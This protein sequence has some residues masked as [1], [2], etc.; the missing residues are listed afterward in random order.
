MEYLDTKS[1]SRYSETYNYLKL[2][3]LSDFEVSGT[4]GNYT[5]FEVDTAFALKK[6][7][8]AILMTANQITFLIKNDDTNESPKTFSVPIEALQKFMEDL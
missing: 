8:L 5:H 6:Q 4:Y 1:K 7:P 3:K 2:R